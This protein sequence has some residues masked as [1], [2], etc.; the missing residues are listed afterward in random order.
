[1]HFFCI[2]S[3]KLFRTLNVGH[4]EEI[5]INLSLM[6]G[7]LIFNDEKKNNSKTKWANV[8]LLAT[9][10]PSTWWKFTADLVLNTYH[11]H[12]ALH[13]LS[14]HVMT[15][16]TYGN[17]HTQ[18]WD[19]RMLQI[20]LFLH[21]IQSLLLLWKQW[22]IIENRLIFAVWV[23]DLHFIETCWMNMNCGA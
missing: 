23:V 22:F 6:K 9:F 16:H 14:H 19:S 11:T 15:T 7:I 13:G 12:F 1:M 18:I 10:T 3:F 21:F 2:C 8:V 4:V 17:T 5:E 20:L